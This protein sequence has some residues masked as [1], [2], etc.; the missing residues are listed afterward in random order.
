M[1]RT[2]FSIVTRACLVDPLSACG[3]KIDRTS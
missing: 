2:L 3:L 1:S